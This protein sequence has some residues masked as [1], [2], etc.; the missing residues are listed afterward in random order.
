MQ[1]PCSV[2]RVEHHLLAARTEAIE[3]VYS[4]TPPRSRLQAP[5]LEQ[6]RRPELAT[7][8][9]DRLGP[10]RAAVDGGAIAESVV[11]PLGNVADVK[12]RHLLASR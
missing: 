9:H 12:R 10:D 5:A 3:E 4:P 2:L 6:R 8:D 1:I 11:D 7:E